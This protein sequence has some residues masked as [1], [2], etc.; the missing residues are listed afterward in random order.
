MKEVAVVPQAITYIC[1]CGAEYHPLTFVIEWNH[2]EV[3]F[4]NGRQGGICPAC[5]YEYVKTICN[6]LSHWA[7]GEIQRPVKVAQR[8]RPGSPM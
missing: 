6:E 2:L 7:V 5:L 3:A 8:E 4:N 1:R